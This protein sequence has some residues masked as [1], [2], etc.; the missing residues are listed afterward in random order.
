MPGGSPRGCPASPFPEQATF[1]ETRTVSDAE[2]VSPICSAKGCRF[3]A[4]WVLC[5]NNPRLHTADR[6][7]TW[8]ACD[9]HLDHLAT[10]LRT[11]GFLRETLA[12]DCYVAQQAPTRHSP[13]QHTSTQG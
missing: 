3:P 6:R 9:E 10:F 5:W 1:W 12:K 7:K 4:A 8:T 2:A 11:R 13:T